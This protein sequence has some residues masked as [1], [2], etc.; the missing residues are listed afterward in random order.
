M[1]KKFEMPQKTFTELC[2]KFDDTIRP[3]INDFLENAK[4]N[5]QDLDSIAQAVA[6]PM[7]MHILQIMLFSSMSKRQIMISFAELFL[8]NEKFFSHGI[9]QKPHEFLIQ[10]I[11]E[12]LLDLGFTRE[13]IVEHVC[14]IHEEYI[15]D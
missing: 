5:H 13:D 12:Y 7:M 6:Q 10:A 8:C 15:N 3:V 4:K 2:H 9:N 1:K 14:K 11:V